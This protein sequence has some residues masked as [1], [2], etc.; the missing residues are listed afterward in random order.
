MLKKLI[1][2]SL[3]YLPLSAFGAEFEFS[4]GAGLQYS[5][6]GTQLAVKHEDSKYFVS[7]GVPGYSLGM[8]TIVSDNE[9]HS[10]GFSLGKLDGLLNDGGRYGLL[11]YNYHMSGFKNDGW[12]FGTGVGFY[13]EKSYTQLFTN[14]RISPSK[15]ALFTIDIGYKF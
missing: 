9:Y 12:V 6:V 13:D 10:L 1:I 14:E 7:V 4:L 5:V 8:Q 3:S 2:I 15:K 11:T